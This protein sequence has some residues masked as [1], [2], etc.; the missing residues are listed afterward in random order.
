MISVIA[1]LPIFITLYLVV[2]FFIGK[3]VFFKQKRPGFHGRIFTIYKFR[4]MT[5]ECDENGKLLEDQKRLTSIGKFVRSLSLDEL[6]QIYNVLKGDL[7]LVG[8]RPLLVEYLDLYTEEEKRRHSV[9]PGITGWA[10]ING[11]N[12]I[13]WKSKF[14]LDLWYVDHWSLW[15]DLKILFLTIIKVIRKSDIQESEKV[16]M[17]PYDG[18]N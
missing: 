15:L 18:T 4:T 11:R 9:K 12:N 16:I 13:S 5:N 6:P 3:P 1:L 2:R 17:T 7:S 10:Q 14:K 8:P